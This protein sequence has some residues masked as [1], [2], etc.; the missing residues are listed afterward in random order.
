LL[1]STGLP[2][3]FYGWRERA[4]QSGYQVQFEPRGN[5]QIVVGPSFFFQASPN[6]PGRPRFRVAAVAVSKDAYKSRFLAD[7][8]LSDKPLAMLEYYRPFGGSPYFIAPGIAFE[9][10]EF[11]RYDAQEHTQHT[12][13]RFSASFYFGIGTWRHIQLRVGG[14]AGFDWYRTP[15]SAD[16]LAVSNTG[17]LN[18][19]AVIIVNTQDSG[20]LPTRGFRL[21]GSAG[22]SSRENPFPYFRSDFDHFHRIGNNVSLLAT[23]Q[24]STSFGRRLTFY[25]E[26]FTGGL[27]QLDAYRYQELRADSIVS[28][29]GGVLYRGL[30]PNSAAFRPIL[31]TWYQ[32]A[33]LDSFDQDSQFK[34]SATVGTFIPTPIGLVGLT[35]SSDLKGSTRFRFSIGSFWN[36]P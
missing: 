1:A 10:A 4:G 6:E 35:F 31:G 28:G 33:G 29:G 21:N 5:T 20:Q 16:G 13:D 34:H 2:M 23:G 19:E 12:R 32:A 9:R 26:F 24:T 17:F 18:P 36:R 3:A 7:F 8:Y 14:Q 27:T 25:D 30:N 15:V 22:W 11:F